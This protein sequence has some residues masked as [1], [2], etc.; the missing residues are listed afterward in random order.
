MLNSNV[1]SRIN[2]NDTTCVR[3][4]NGIV[5]NN[6]YRIKGFEGVKIKTKE[7]SKQLGFS[8]NKHLMIV[9]LEV[10]E[11]AHQ[12]DS[13]LYSRSDF[14]KNYQYPLDIRLPI[15]IGN[16]LILNDEKERLLAKLTLSDIVKIEYLDHQN[17]KVNRSITPFGVI[18]LS[19]KQK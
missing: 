16:K 12:V 13:V 11:I 5:V 4:L 17:P 9:T 18:N 1:G 14:I 10:P 7:D 2:V 6:N 15:S 3:I 8:G 19:V